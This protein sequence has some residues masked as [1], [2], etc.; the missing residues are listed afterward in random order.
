MKSEVWRALS[1]PSRRRIL[2]LLRERPQT[3]GELAGQ[4][5]QSRYGGMKHLTVLTEAGLIVVERRGRE[6]WNHLNAV[7][8]RE[9]YERWLGPFQEFWSSSLLRLRDHLT[10]DELSKNQEMSM[11]AF[12]SFDIQQEV[13]FDAT[14]EKVWAALT[15]DI[16]K[17]WAF[18]VG[19]EGS[20]ITLEPR[21]GGHFVERWGDGEGTI[22]GTVVDFRLGKQ[23][24]L[25]GGLGMDGAGI[26]DYKYELEAKGDKTLLKLSHHGIG[27]RDPKSEQNYREGWT[28]LLEK[29][30]IAWLDKGVT[31]DESGTQA[32]DQCDS[33]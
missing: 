20:S 16:G 6:R 24:R 18:R 1:D 14:T 2:D 30:L 5:D 23:L 3:T 4:F 26:N 32:D 31:C 33:A 28:T 17:W 27:Y 29:H 11:S 8:L 19:E 10:T 13:T 7:P 21:L 25:K 12:N 15:T 9:I 22:W